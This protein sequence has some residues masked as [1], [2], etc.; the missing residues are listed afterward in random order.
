VREL[1]RLAERSGEFAR[2]GAR[3]VAVALQTREELADLQ[4]AL[5]DG[6]T[7]VA[8]P[9]GEAVDAWHMRDPTP[10]PPRP[11]ARA[12]TFLVDPKGVVR[13]HWLKAAYHER[14]EPDEILA[15]LR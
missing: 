15:L 3:V 4:A 12:G 9:T 10:V 6:V 2:L 1:G 8:D 7:V 11:M 5:G 14:P 13:S